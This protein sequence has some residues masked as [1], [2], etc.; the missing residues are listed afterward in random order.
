[1]VIVDDDEEMRLLIEAMVRM[2][3]GA[4][5]VGTGANGDEAVDLVAALRPDVLVL[6][7]VMPVRYGGDAIP[8]IRAASPGTCIVM[9]SATILYAVDLAERD[10]GAGNLPDRFVSKADG[11]VGLHLAVQACLQRRAA[12]GG[13]DRPAG[14]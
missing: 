9:F 10:D 5:V 11:L 12:A 6:D 1:V 13:N 14:C 2:R 8:E 7:H 4:D 3:L